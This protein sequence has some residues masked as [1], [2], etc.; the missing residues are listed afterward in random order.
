V[1]ESN[2]GKVIAF[3]SYKGGTGR[4]M[5]LANVGCA[6]ARDPKLQRPVLL[7]DWDLEAPGLHRYFRKQVVTQFRGEEGQFDKA[8]GLIDLFHE[9]RSRIAPDG[10]LA[11]H[12]QDYESVAPLFNDF[13]LEKYI[14]KTDVPRLHLIKAGSFGNA[15]AANIASFQWPELYHRSPYLLRAFADRLASDYS[16]VVIDSRTGLTD[17]SGICAMLMPEVL[18]AVFTPNRQSL[19]GVIDLVREAAS[20]RAKSDDLRPLMVYPLPSRIEASEP[21]LRHSWRFGDRS[22]GIPGFQGMFEEAFKEIYEL[23]ACDLGSYF[24]DVQ[25]QH[26][27]DYAYG[28]EIALLVEQTHDRLSLTHSY[29]RFTARLAKGDLPWASPTPRE[30][31]FQEQII[32]ERRLPLESGWRWFLSFNSRDQA[33][34]EAF[35]VAIERAQPASSLYFAPSQLRAGASWSASLVQGIA[36]AKGFILLIGAHGLSPWQVIEYDEAIDR[37]VKSPDFPIVLVLLEGQTAPG[38]PFLR[39][40]PWVVT[41]D[42]ASDKTVAQVIDS[43]AGG[44]AAQGNL[45]R[46]TA[47]YRGLAAMT[48]ADADFFF[49]RERE[50]VEVIEALAAMPDKMPLLIGNS[51][52]G[53]TSLAEAGV[54]AGLLRQ[55]WPQTATTTVRPWPNALNDSRRWCVLKLRPGTDPVRALVESFFR[56]W[57]FDALDPGRLTR[58]AEW[59]DGLLKRKVTLNDLIDETERRLQDLRETNPPGYLIY[60]DQGEELYVRAEEYQRRCFSELVAKGLGAHRVRV[61][62]SLRSDFL[63]ELQRDESFLTVHR[64]INVPPMREAELLEV[65]SR[66]AELLGAR[67]ET[68]RLAYDIAARAAYDSV[69]N[70]GSLPLLSYL[71]DDMW[72]QMVKRDDAVLRLPAHSLEL[73]DVLG[74]RA[75]AFLALH[76]ESAN[77][78]RRIFTLHLTTIRED[79]EPTRRRARRSEFSDEEWRLITQLADHPNRLVM[80]ASTEEGEVY[81]E[82]AQDAVFRRW[83]KVREWIANEREFLAWRSG[84]E[85]AH[86]DWQAAPDASK[87]DALLMGV[88]LARAH[89]WL[90]KR[91]QD[92]AGLDREFIM[93]S[94]ARER[95]AQAR[96]SRTRALAY[97]LLVGIIVGLVGWINQHYI[98]QQWR[99]YT[100][101]RPFMA[102][103]IQPYVLTTQAE[104]ALKPGE[105]FRECTSEPAKDY[106]PEM[107]VVPAGSFLMGSSQSEAGRYPNEGPQHEVKIARLFAVSKF[108]LTFDDWDTCVAYGDCGDVSDAGW[109]RGRR[110]VILVSW[111]DAQQYVRWLSKIT[112]KSYRLLSEA[113]YEY[114][115]R[116]GTQ[117]HYPWG[118]DIGKSNA[119]CNG[120]G[121]QWDI[122]TA[123]VGSFAPNAFGL[124]DMVGNVSEWVEDCYHPNYDGAPADG[125]AWISGG[126]EHRVARGGSWSSIPPAL[127]SASRQA[128]TTAY[129]SS[130]VGFRIA[131]TL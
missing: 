27:P 45:W 125:S 101:Q 56:I 50:T 86:R 8:P 32:F 30:E 131:R 88:A 82:V 19:F 66:P 48:E 4:T 111:D 13:Q 124:Y 47:P 35:K 108:E 22:A 71:L 128:N 91:G 122:Q 21:A 2:L 63:G 100:I 103:N 28:E 123:P 44:G 33:L 90:D 67:F 114:A 83:S 12:E 43:A 117:S 97:V 18:V 37:R 70:T 112:G 58:V 115:A 74:K 110:P 77:M 14:I 85:A 109:G 73:G 15:Y 121:S 76:P 10:D 68:D 7:V 59:T 6:L 126:C 99:W 69:R 116:A 53:K 106:C 98:N 120:C 29:L 92:L 102:A 95:R 41:S 52:V 113:E 119:N 40:C 129:Q 104:Q 94:M 1:I 60:I 51:G 36:E 16:F 127:R 64:L 11:Q 93:R 31:T 55:S 34:A 72:Q 26:L 107:V 96:V 105:T 17:T 78:L 87:Q 62:M 42:P 61:M 81:A 3:Y 23:P 79:G 5:A 25:I 118:D 38:L 39:R 24:D 84:L 75:D 9:L 130:N 57:R 89:R 65:V 46:Y 49:G 20:Y 80:T 54:L